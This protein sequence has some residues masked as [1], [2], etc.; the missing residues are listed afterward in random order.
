[1]KKSSVGFDFPDYK[2]LVTGATSGIG[3]AVAL[4]FAGA[5]AGLVLT[6]RDESRG[7]EVCGEIEALGRGAVFIPGDLTDPDDVR[8]HSVG[9]TSG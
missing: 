5:G 6:G 9:V 2:V 1:M 7:V 4:A 3:R 8:M